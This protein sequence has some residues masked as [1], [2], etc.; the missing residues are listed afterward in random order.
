MWGFWFPSISHRY[1]FPSRTGSAFY[2]TDRDFR[3]EKLFYLRDLQINTENFPQNN[4]TVF[5][6]KNSYLI[7]IQHSSL[8]Q[9]DCTHCALLSCQPSSTEPAV[10][11]GTAE[12][13]DEEA[14][15]S[16]PSEASVPGGSGRALPLQDPRAFSLLPFLPCHPCRSE[17]SLGLDHCGA[18]ATNDLRSQ[19]EHCRNYTR[20]AFSFQVFSTPW[21]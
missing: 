14:S 18:G 8:R 16:P 1:K 12:I 19:T 17:F 21:K 6:R 7:Q 4:P 15:Q 3:R 5:I 2:A 13:K 9:A 20:G 11:S 10:C